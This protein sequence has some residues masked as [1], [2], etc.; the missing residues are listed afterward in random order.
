MKSAYNHT[1][2]RNLFIVKEAKRWRDHQIISGD[3]FTTIAGEYKSSFYHPNLMIRILL[4]VASLIGLGGITGI[5]ALIFADGLSEHSIFTLSFIY[6]VASFIVLDR[7]FIAK[8][9]HYKSGLT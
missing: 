3:Q 8:L 9:N 1:W 6:G 7:V 2:L 4:F 5:L